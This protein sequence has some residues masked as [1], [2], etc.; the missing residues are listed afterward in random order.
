MKVIISKL[1]E[2]EEMENAVNAF[3]CTTETTLPNATRYDP[4]PESAPLYEHTLYQDG[5]DDDDEEEEYCVGDMEDIH[6]TRVCSSNGKP[7][8][9]G[10]GLIEVS[11]ANEHQITGSAV[12]NAR[13][14]AKTSTKRKNKVFQSTLIYVVTKKEVGLPFHVDALYLL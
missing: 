12:S 11:I 10:K 14:V 8:E 6:T 4:Y 9:V 2:L 3:Y 5:D 7:K 13:L 1:A